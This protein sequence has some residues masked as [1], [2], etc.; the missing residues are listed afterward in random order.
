MMK[1]KI[2]A[3]F[4]TLGDTP[5]L[6]HSHYLSV[7][8]I[9]VHPQMIKGLKRALLFPSTPHLPEIMKLLRYVISSKAPLDSSW[10]S[11]QALPSNTHP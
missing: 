4:S 7:F 11:S 9:S 8:Q 6:F 3:L 5:L 2:E 10:T 1:W